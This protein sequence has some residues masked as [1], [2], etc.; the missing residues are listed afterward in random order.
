MNIL[1]EDAMIWKRFL[2]FPIVGEIHLSL[3]ESCTV[4]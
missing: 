3:V 4:G 1:L 2:D